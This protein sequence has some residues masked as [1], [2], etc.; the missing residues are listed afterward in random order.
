MARPKTKK[1]YLRLANELAEALYRF[2]FCGP[3]LRIVMWIARNS[4][5][6][7]GREDTHRV[8]VRE[9]ARELGDAPPATIGWA[10]RGLL[11]RGLVIRIQVSGGLRLNTN[12]EE[13]MP[14]RTGQLG[15]LANT[16]ARSAGPSD[17]PSHLEPRRKP[18]TPPTREDV[19][20][21]CLERNNAVDPAKFW[22][23]YDKAKWR[24]GRDQKPVT[25]W[26]TLVCYWER[27][28]AK[29]PAAPAAATPP[30]PLCEGPKP[31]KHALACDMC[32]AYCRSCSQKDA[33]LKVV[34]RP[35][36]TKTLRCRGK[37]QPPSGQLV[38]AAMPAAMREAD[39]AR[40]R[41]FMTTHRAR[42]EARERT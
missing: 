35:D 6:W 12:Y 31:D 26:K 41:K 3:E 8:S 38:K 42:G 20:A 37:C 36:G 28:D 18:F 15:L 27:E 21:Y 19:A 1:G 14:R 4:Y 13:W 5:G 23:H 22:K 39:E 25:N 40:N 29:R 30:C 7:G 16:T 17:A 11:D 10:L 9:L 2:P 24:S 33:P 34:A 32:G